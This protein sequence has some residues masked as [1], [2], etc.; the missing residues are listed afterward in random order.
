MQE[1]EGRKAIVDETGIIDYA[2]FKQVSDGWLY[3]IDSD[4]DQLYIGPFDTF[5]EAYNDAA[6]LNGGL[7]LDDL[8]PP[9]EKKNV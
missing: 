3:L 5:I 8:E 6:W 2:Y 4:P 9:L 1:T 7:E